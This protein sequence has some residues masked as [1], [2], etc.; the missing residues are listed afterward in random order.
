MANERQRTMFVRLA[1]LTLFT[2]AA[3]G[4]PALRA[5]D[6]YL[7]VAGRTEQ[8]AEFIAKER[9]CRPNLRMTRPRREHGT[10]SQIVVTVPETYSPAAVE[11]LSREAKAA[12]L[13]YGVKARRS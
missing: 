13:R 2:L 11:Q 9:S 7:T 6:R 12:G 1:P 4:G 5:T 3:C 8:V 10:Q